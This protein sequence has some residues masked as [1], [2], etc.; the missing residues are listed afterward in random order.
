MKL[1]KIMAG[2]LSVATALS[3]AG[4][5]SNDNPGNSSNSSNSSSSSSSSS[6]SSGNSTS[7]NSTSSTTVDNPIDNETQSVRDNFFDASKITDGLTLKPYRPL[8]RFPAAP[9]MDERV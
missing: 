9:G 6:T 2:V 5:N 4:C 1:K 8:Q 3:F 7:D